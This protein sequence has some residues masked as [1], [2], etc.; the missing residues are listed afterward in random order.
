MMGLLQAQSVQTEQKQQDWLPL[1]S[2]QS[3]SLN[4]ITATDKDLADY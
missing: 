1:I 2:G 4:N 3:S